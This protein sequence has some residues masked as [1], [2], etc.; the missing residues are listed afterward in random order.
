MEEYGLK[1]L[2]NYGA[3]ALGWIVAGVLWNRLST[4]TDQYIALAKENIGVL[5]RLEAKID[6]A[7]KS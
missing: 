5:A 6:A 3:V 7:K 2:A 1:A 4:L